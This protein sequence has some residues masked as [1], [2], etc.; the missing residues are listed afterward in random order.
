MYLYER[1]MRETALQI[2]VC[3]CLQKCQAYAQ[4]FE[5]PQRQLSITCLGTLPQTDIGYFKQFINTAPERAFKESH[6][7]EGCSLFL[8]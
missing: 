2:R 6:G 8:F 7:G 1:E 4:M 3:C 5:R